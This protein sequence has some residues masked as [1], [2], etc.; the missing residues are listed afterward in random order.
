MFSL[1]GQSTRK[2]AVLILVWC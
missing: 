1:N 2:S